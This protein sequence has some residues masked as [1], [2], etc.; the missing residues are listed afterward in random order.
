MF[1]V[2][3]CRISHFKCKL[4]RRTDEREDDRVTEAFWSLESGG[5]T[6][7]PRAPRPHRFYF[8]RTDVLILPDFSKENGTAKKR[9]R[10]R[11]RDKNPPNGKGENS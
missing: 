3:S 7:R 10:E 1:P 9:E 11:E 8:P 6:E 2:E 4:K 5:L